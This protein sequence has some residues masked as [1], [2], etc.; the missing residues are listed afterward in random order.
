MKPLFQKSVRLTLA[1][2]ALVAVSSLNSCVSTNIRSARVRTYAGAPK[3]IFLKVQSNPE[4]NMFLRGIAWKIED[5]LRARG[6]AVNLYIYEALSDRDNARMIEKYISTFGAD[7]VLEMAQTAQ[8]SD[9]INTVPTY[10]GDTFNGGQSYLHSSSTLSLRLIDRTNE[11]SVWKAKITN[12]TNSVFSDMK[13]GS[14]VEKTARKVIEALVKDGI[15]QPLEE[16][17]K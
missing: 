12:K 14:G 9:W 17:N 8:S 7:L 2:L 15:L 13:T 10:T 16:P 6:I 1:V 4:Y 5:A 11:Q 3:K